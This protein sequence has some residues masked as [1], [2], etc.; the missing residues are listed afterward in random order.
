MQNW[1]KRNWRSRKYKIGWQQGHFIF[2]SHSVS[3][4]RAHITR[5]HTSSAMDFLVLL[6]SNFLTFTCCLVNCIRKNH[7]SHGRPGWRLPHF[8]PEFNEVVAGG[9]L[10]LSQG[11]GPL[12]Q[13]VVSW[14]LPRSS[15]FS[16]LGESH[17]PVFRW[18]KAILLLRNHLLQILNIAWALEP[19]HLTHGSYPAI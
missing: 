10:A 1:K 17:L 3:K 4:T 7:Y 6:L 11:E 12:F 16:E 5:S 15:L 13:I 2:S 14:W 8:G 19:F 18:V 9:V